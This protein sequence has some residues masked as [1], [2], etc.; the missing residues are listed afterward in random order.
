MENQNSTDHLDAKKRVIVVGAGIAGL[1]VASK[2]ID[3]GLDVVI[4]EARDR[5]GGRI[6]TDHEDGDNIDMGAAWMHATS[7]NPLVK[8]ISRLGIE[9]YYND[10]NSAYFTEFGPA[11]PNFKAQ[12][13]AYEF[14]D[15]LN[16]WNLKSPDSPDYS[17]EEH[18]RMFVKQQELI[19]EDEKIWAPEALRIIEP[20]FG[21][22]LSEISSRFLNDI[23]P[24]QRDLYVTGGYDRVVNHLAQPVLELPG[25]LRL[26]H[27]V[28]R[29]EWNR[30]G[31]T[32][33]VSVHAIDAEGNHYAVDGEAVVMTAPLGVLHQQK[34]A[35]EPPI[36]SDLALGTSKI[37]YGTLGKVFF[38]FTEV[39]WSTQND[40]LIYF[41]TPATL[42]D[43]SQ[44]VKYPVL[45]HSFLATNLWIMTGVKKLCIFVTPP[46][47]HEIERMGENQQALFEY[48][49]PLLKLFRTEPYKTLPKM[50]EAKVTSWTKDDFAGNGSYSTAKVGDDPH[51]LWDALDENKDSILQFAG[52]HCSRT[53][54]GCVH[55][56]YES[57]EAAADNIVRILRQ[58]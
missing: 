33:P 15:Y 44:K 45:S 7:Y 48:F 56:A 53:G 50:V 13:V 10:G 43:D 24:P 58:Q 32:S 46:V 27:V 20:T 40:N 37:S 9:Y 6:V 36:P 28:N 8:L 42:A 39:F 52:D 51:V 11:G 30:S 22:A 41:P 54:T 31:N 2:L 25:A 21:L 16:Y 4:L 47:V 35:F 12:N 18:I 29:V 57:G 17:A 23:L 55:G 38:K 14:L 1:C 49:E 5:I 19:S 3:E 34:I 26:R